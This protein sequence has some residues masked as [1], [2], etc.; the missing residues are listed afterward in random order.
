[1]TAKKKDPKATPA[2]DPIPV[3]RRKTGAAS[4]AD[5][6]AAEA[7][8][9]E[10]R[11]GTAVI[12]AADGCCGLS[13]RVTSGRMDDGDI[14]ALAPDLPASSV[15]VS[16]CRDGATQ[17]CAIVSSDLCAAV[18]EMQTLGRLKPNPA[19]DRAA[20]A[21]DALLA[22]PFIALLLEELTKS[23]PDFDAA[24]SVEIGARI[25]EARRLPQILAEAKLRDLTAEVEFGEGGR[26]GTVRLLLP[27][28][29]SSDAPPH[30]PPSSDWSSDLEKTVK[31]ARAK[32]RAVLHRAA[33]TLDRLEALAVGDLLPLSGCT[34]SDVRIETLDGQVVAT[35]RLGQSAGLRA[36]RIE[37]A[38]ARTMKDGITASGPPAQEVEDAPIKQAARA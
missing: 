19:E 17:G 29:A 18:I 32:L 33:Y 6:G 2:K 31:A 1:M 37:P 23:L 25:A 24:T 13:L 15:I 7:D 3:L 11:L 16:L 14:D 30:P 38:P 28:V 20:T 9:F 36:V 34:L 10:K 26:A 21:T 4:R 35:G 12:R 27:A 22:G 5:P 8:L